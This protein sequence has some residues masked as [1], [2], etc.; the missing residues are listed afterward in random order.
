MS[1]AGGEATLI[2]PF[3]Y[4]ERGEF[5]APDWSPTSDEIAFAGRWRGEFQIMLGKASRPG[6]A[7]QLTSSGRNE[8][9]SWAPDGRHIVYTGVGRDTNSLYIIDTVTG[10]IRRLISGTKLQMADWSPVLQ[11]IPH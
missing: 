11:A 4:G 1:A 2:P 7:T 8:D 9:P 3:S 5:A 10:T 6:V